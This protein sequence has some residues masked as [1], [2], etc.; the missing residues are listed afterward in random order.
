MRCLGVQVI[1]SAYEE[2]QAQNTTLLQQMTERDAVTHKL[3]S[4]RL[5]LDQQANSM[6]EE[7]ALFQSKVTSMARVAMAMTNNLIDFACMLGKHQANVPTHHLGLSTSLTDHGS[8]ARTGTTGGLSIDDMK[9]CQVHIMHNNLSRIVAW[10]ISGML[11]CALLTL[12]ESRML[13]SIGAMGLPVRVARSSP[14]QAFNWRR[15][16][17]EFGL[18]K[19]L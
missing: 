12:L 8:H 13:V 17:E 5:Q 19:S 2:M 3:Q 18:G 10:A 7:K 15:P 6:Q 4:E 14:R 1:G 16:I 9:K 11:S